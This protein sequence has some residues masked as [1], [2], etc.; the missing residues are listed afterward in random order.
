ME[1]PT[2]TTTD[3]QLVVGDI[4]APPPGLQ[5]RPA[6]L[7]QL[8]RASQKPPVVLTGTWGT[9]KTQL[10]ATYARARLADS[11]RLI[12]WINARNSE[13]LLAGLAAVAKAAGL[14]AGGSRPGPADAGRAV[15]DWLEADGR[16]RLLVFDDVEDLGLLRPF[17]PAA[18]EARVLITAAREPVAEL[19][20]VVPVDVFS[21]EEALAL[22]DGRTGLADEAGASAVASELGRLPL[23]LD[24][25][26]AVIAGGAPELRGVPGKPA[27]AVGRGL[28][29]PVG[30]R[31]A[32][33]VAGRCGGG[34]AVPRCRVRCRPTRC[35]HRGDGAHGHA[36]A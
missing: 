18:G 34:A 14:P 36:V 3:E 5:P 23:V 4:P 29:V 31:R 6:L 16:F 27:G 25:S 7:A 13:N 2:L 33:V 28:P 20:T 24:Q 21:A 32:A 15:R 17:V 35:V 1:A 8:N 11:W 10:A 9:G 30:G 19:G 22:L 12:A 26:A